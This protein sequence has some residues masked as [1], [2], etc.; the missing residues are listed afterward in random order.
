MSKIS[1]SGTLRQGE[2]VNRMKQKGID[3]IC[4]T[5]GEPD[6]DTPK[7]VVNTCI[8]ALKAGETHYTPSAGK[9]ELK[10]AVSG[11]LVKENRVP[12][13]PDNIIISPTKHLIYMSL[14]AILEEGDEVIIPSPAWPSYKSQVLLTGGNP[15]FV[16]GIGEKGFSLDLGGMER[17]V[18]TRTKAIILCNPSNPTG[19]MA[20]KK[21]LERLA[22]ICKDED[23]LVISDEVYE[24]LV[25][26]GN[27][28]SIGSLPEMAER[29]ITVGGLSKSHAMTGWRAGWL[30]GPEETVRDITK[31]QQHTVTCTPEFIQ[32]AM[33]EALVGPKEEVNSLVKQFKSRRDLMVKLMSKVDGLTIDSVPQGAF[34]LFPRF[35]VDMTSWDLAEKILK[36]GHVGVTAG[37]AF[38]PGGS[39]RLRFSYATGTERI[40]EGMKRVAKVFDRL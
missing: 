27:H 35:T 11:K 8:K 38:G 39:G 34:Y 7:N 1:A 28:V 5:L 22:K 31:I 36:E 24:R 14:M 21:E 15:I 29:T 26:R 9:Y 4:F 25:Y 37:D 3:V 17:A 30:S 18:T 32:D 40:K 20:T 13:T 2:L 10:K 33:L 23:I 19:N 12:S 6:F 16:E